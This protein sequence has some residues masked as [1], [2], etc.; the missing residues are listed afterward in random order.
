MFGGEFFLSVCS[1]TPPWLLCVGQR[2][3]SRGGSLPPGCHLNPVPGATSSMAVTWFWWPAFGL[4]PPGCLWAPPTWAPLHSTHLGLPRPLRLPPDMIWGHHL[5]SLGR[6]LCSNP[7]TQGPHGAQRRLDPGHRQR[8]LLRS[9]LPGFC[10]VV[11]SHGSN[12]KFL[13]DMSDLALK[14][15]CKLVICPQ[16]ENRNDRWIQVGG[17]GG[18]SPC[19]SPRLWEMEPAQL[20]SP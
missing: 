4:H 7:E 17:L 10:S 9:P 18:L 13:E 15:N 11:D 14:A 8:S 2:G 12:K 6:G 1:R 3:R 20:W 16:I 19:P 5:P